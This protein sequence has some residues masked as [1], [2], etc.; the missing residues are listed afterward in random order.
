MKLQAY[1]STEALLAFV[2]VIKGGR[3]QQ[4]LVGGACHLGVTQGG[5]GLG[6]GGGLP[7]G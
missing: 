6:Q 5:G 1:R 4:V 7:V 3:R 2:A